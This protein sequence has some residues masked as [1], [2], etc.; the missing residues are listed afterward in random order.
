MTGEPPA[1]PDFS[2]LAAT[3]ARSRPTYPAA[4]Y[5]WLAGLVERRELAWDC[6]TGSGQAA[7]GLAAHFARV[8]HDYGDGDYSDTEKGNRIG[9]RAGVRVSR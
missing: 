2:P 4:L 9:M 5:E 3:Y 1:A 7:L 6:A 8:S